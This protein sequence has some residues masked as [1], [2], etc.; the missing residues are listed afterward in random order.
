M[1]G[2]NWN[3]F[4][5]F[6]QERPNPLKLD[7]FQLLLEFIRNADSLMGPDDLYEFLMDDPLSRQMLE[8]REI[9]TVTALEEFLYKLQLNKQP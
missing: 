9:D 8:K 2:I 5:L 1:N 7:N 4:K 6:K 3:Q